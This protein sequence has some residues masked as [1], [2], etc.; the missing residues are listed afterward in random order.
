MKHRW[1]LL[2]TS[3]SKSTNIYQDPD[4]PD[5]EQIKKAV[6]NIVLND[7]TEPVVEQ[8]Y[9][10]VDLVSPTKN[11]GNNED[12]LSSM[13]KELSMDINKP[14]DNSIV[15]IDKLGSPK[16]TVMF[17]IIKINLI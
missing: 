1:I 10:N 13:I 8:S 15:K 14:S 7:I 12:K 5:E 6:Q 9:D 16:S 3:S 2:R 11:N 17:L 4:D